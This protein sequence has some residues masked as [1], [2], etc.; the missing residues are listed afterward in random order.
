MSEAPS[1]RVPLTRREKQVT[2]SL[3]VVLL[4]VAVATIGAMAI[5]MSCGGPVGGGLQVI[6]ASPLP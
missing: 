4:V 6:G 2:R 3:A 1:G 5:F